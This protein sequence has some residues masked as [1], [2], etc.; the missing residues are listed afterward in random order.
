LRV[1][2][3]HIQGGEGLAYITASAEILRATAKHSGWTTQDTEDMKVMITSISAPWTEVEGLTRINFFM[4]QGWY[5]NNGAMTIAVFGENRT[6]YEKMIH[7]AT[8]GSNP[9]P[10]LDYAVPRQILNDTDHLGQVVE[11]GRDEYHPMGTLRGLSLSG[12]TSLIQR[13]IDYFGMLDNR[14]MHGWEYW[15]KYNNGSDVNWKPLF[16]GAGDESWPI[17]SPNGRGRNYE[18][19]WQPVEAIGIGY[20]EYSR[21]GKARCVPWLTEY[22]SWQ[23]VGWSTFE[24]GFD[25]A[26]HH[27]G[28]SLEVVKRT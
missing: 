4:N 17:V 3:E 27:L 8:V 9:I 18:Q 10:S 20:Y 1:L 28:Y 2:N 25:K 19:Y 6:L 16:I 12:H 26:I 15:A 24:W 21:R 22:M 5:G 11:M 7:Q 13:G 14:L 23:G